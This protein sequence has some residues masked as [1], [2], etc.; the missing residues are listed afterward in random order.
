MDQAFRIENPYHR[1]DA[2]KRLFNYWIGSDQ[3]V[4]GEM[5]VPEHFRQG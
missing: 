3:E 5:I 1:R 4:Q 2:L